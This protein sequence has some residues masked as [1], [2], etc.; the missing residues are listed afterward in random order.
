[1]IIIRKPTVNDVD[2][3]F[4]LT[5]RMA[6][7]GLMLSRSKYRITTMLQNFVVAEDDQTNKVIGCGAFS[8]LWTDLGEVMALAIEEEYQKQGVGSRIVNTLLEEARKLQ[9]PQVITLTYKPEFFKRLGFQITDK[10]RFPRKLWRECL[11]CPKLETCD[12]ILL[13]IIIR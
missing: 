9:V 12:E 1:M 3:I 6:Q 4:T 8:L 13:H 11:E 5:N 10:D 7:K 2:T